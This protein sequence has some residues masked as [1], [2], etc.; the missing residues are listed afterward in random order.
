MKETESGQTWFFLLDR[1]KGQSLSLLLLPQQ[2]VGLGLLLAYGQVLRAMSPVG[3]GR[4]K[5][6][7]LPFQAA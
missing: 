4:G 5:R 6:V 3:M 7:P 2:W 1:S